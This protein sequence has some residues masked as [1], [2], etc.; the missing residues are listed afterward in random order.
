MGT[1]PSFLNPDKEI[2]E[3]QPPVYAPV[4]FVIEVMKYLRGKG[5]SLIQNAWVT[6]NCWS[7][8]AKGQRSRGSNYGGVKANKHN[9]TKN[10]EWWRAPGHT[11]SGDAPMCY[12]KAYKDL[13]HFLD[14][15]CVNYI[16]K[17][18]DDVQPE[19]GKTANYK[20][21]GFYFWNKNP[22]WY[23]AIIGAEYK[24]PMTR[25]IPE[26]RAGSIENHRR[27]T[28]QTIITY[29]Q[30]KLG[31]GLVCDGQ[32]GPKTKKELEKVFPGKN[33]MEA[34]ELLYQSEN[35]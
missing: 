9:T 18:K 13:H 17:P 27:L 10:D 34:A 12:Y 21:A 22:L 11:K 31:N 25:D 15:W 35:T 24:G 19:G 1:I 7:E 6:A 30:Y 3:P 14:W 2:K 33:W 4:E 28:E 8:S 26:R 29:L 5:M 32:F 23:D 20:L 16:P